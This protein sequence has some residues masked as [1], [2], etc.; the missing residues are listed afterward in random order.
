MVISYNHGRKALL[1]R[2]THF[3]IVREEY[4]FFSQ[5]RYVGYYKNNI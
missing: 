2:G 4:F 1:R 3:L 5:K